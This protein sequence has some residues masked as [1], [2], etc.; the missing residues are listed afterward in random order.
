VKDSFFHIWLNGY[1][2]P[3]QA[4]KALSKKPAPFYGLYAIL[5]RGA[6]ISLLWM[7]PRAIMNLEPMSLPALPFLTSANYYWHAIWLYPVFEF[8]RW[9]LFCAFIHLCLRLFKQSSSFDSI[10]NITG[11][12]SL[13]IEPIVRLWDWIVLLLGWND[14]LMFLGISHALL[15]WPWSLVLI[16]I[17][18]KQILRIS[19]RWSVTV[20]FLASML[21][22][23]L[24]MVFL[25]P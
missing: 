19:P 23:P 21:F 11:M 12:I 18:Y 8:S 4:F 3:K 1:F 16:A 25:R 10:L 13:M 17:A 2:H 6:I 22:I 14:D 5:L 20:G 9:L 7:L 24:A 15:A